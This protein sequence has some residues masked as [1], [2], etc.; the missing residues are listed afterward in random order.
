MA[1]DDVKEKEDAEAKEAEKEAEDTEEGEEEGEEGGKK[2]KKG[3]RLL[4]LIVAAGILMGGA[5]GAV[6]FLFMGGEEETAEALEEQ[7]DPL[8]ELSDIAF[9]DVPQI[10]VNLLTDSRV[11]RFLKVKISLELTSEADVPVLEKLMPRVMDDFQMFLRQ[12]RVEDIKGSTGMHR[13]K[14][15]LLLRAQQ[16]AAPVKV[17]NVLFKEI[18]VQ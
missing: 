1:D 16:S 7:V 14:E 5:I 2:K 18:I 8:A 15:G 12:L 6:V 9:Y 17:R 4:V 10:S 11:T 3:N 13:L